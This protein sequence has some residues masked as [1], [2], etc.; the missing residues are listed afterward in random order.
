M[1]EFSLQAAHN[2]SMFESCKWGATELNCTD[3]LRRIATGLGFCYMFHPVY[4]DSSVQELA[5]ERTGSSYGMM[6][7]IN[8]NYEEYFYGNT[9]GVGMKVKIC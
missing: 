1:Y 3:Y 2:M 6:F 4:K 8:V 7:T 5:V 9:I